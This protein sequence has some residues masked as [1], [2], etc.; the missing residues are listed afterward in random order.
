MTSCDYSDGTREFELRLSPQGGTLE[1]TAAQALERSGPNG[2]VQVTV[3]ADGSEKSVQNVGFKDTIT[4]SES[5]TGV[6]VIKVEAKLQ[7]KE[8][9]QECPYT[10]LMVSDLQITAR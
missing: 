1:F 5:I 3:F 7:R 9:G 2:Q 10:T 4:F 6:A 8:V